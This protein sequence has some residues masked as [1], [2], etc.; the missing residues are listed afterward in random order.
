MVKLSFIS[1]SRDS[2]SSASAKYSGSRGADHQQLQ[3]RQLARLGRI[4]QRNLAFA[5]DARRFSRPPAR[6]SMRGWRPRGGLFF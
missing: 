6:G 2:A 5:L 1:T 3:W 4:E